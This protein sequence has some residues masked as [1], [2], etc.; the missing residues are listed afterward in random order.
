MSEDDYLQH[1]LEFCGFINE[2]NSLMLVDGYYGIK[3]TAAYPEPNT[4]EGLRLV[5]KQ[6]LDNETIQHYGSRKQI[7]S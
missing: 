6:I 3:L 7:N 4:Y 2:P 5:H 1:F